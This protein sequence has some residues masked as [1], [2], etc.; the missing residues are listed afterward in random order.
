MTTFT[1]VLDEEAK[2]TTFSTAVI[3][4]WAPDG[5]MYWPKKIPKL[6]RDTLRKFSTLSYPKL[7]AEILK[8]YLTPG[9][10]DLTAY[11]VDRILE[12]AFDVFG[13]DEVVRLNDALIRTKSSV[14]SSSSTVRQRVTIAELWHGPTL[15]FKDL[16]MTVLGRILDHL[17]KKK[18]TTLTLLVGTSGD[19]GSSAMEAVRGLKGVQIVVLYPKQGYASITPVQER[20]M[21]SVAEAEENVHCVAVEGTSDDLDVPMEK[22][23]RDKAFKTEM[24]LGSVNSVNIVRMLVQTVHYFY[25]Y[26]RIY[27]D[28]DEGKKVRFVV[29]SG[30]GGHLCAGVLA[31]QMGL[32]AQLTAATNK[33]DALHQ[34]LTTGTMRAANTRS[35]VSPSM[36]IQVPYNVWRMLFLAS[37]GNAAAVKRWQ[38]A[39]VESKSGMKVKNEIMLKLKSLVDSV[40]VSDEETLVTIRDTYEKVAYL[41]DPHTAVGVAAVNARNH[42]R[43]GEKEDIPVV[44]MACAHPMKFLPIVMRALKCSHEEALEKASES[45]RHKCVDAV[46]KIAKETSANDTS[47]IKRPAGCCAVFEEGRDWEAELRTIVRGVR[48]KTLALSRSDSSYYESGEMLRKAFRDEHRRSSRRFYRKIAVLAGSALVIAGLVAALAYSKRSQSKKNRPSRG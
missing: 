2:E 28:A 47:S 26:L 4:G 37:D 15:A 7:C 36:D 35:T 11:D 43:R 32:P 24:N 8:L 33:N 6:S 40:A 42:R 25:A 3:N 19:T 14:S 5:G 38:R 41:L 31:T 39:F 44:A 20:Q 13:C 46:A 12:D 18:K 29:P 22:C 16:G 27:P 21:T 45:A 48:S 10:G 23:F 9:D 30:A 34:F 17:V 1:S